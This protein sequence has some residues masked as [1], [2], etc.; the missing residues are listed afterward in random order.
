M[1][2]TKKDIEIYSDTGQGDSFDITKILYENEYTIFAEATNE[3]YT[4]P[5]NVM[6][7]KETNTVYG[8]NLIFYYAKN[9]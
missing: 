2:D 4:E 7:D 9:K 8:K 6:I 3:W 5:I 1:I